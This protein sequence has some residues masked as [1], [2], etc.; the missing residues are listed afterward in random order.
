MP[1]EARITLVGHAVPCVTPTR[2]LQGVCA[3]CAYLSACTQQLAMHLVLLV[4]ACRAK[5]AGQAAKQLRHH[6]K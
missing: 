2:L 6:V 5:L 4:Q 3:K 1:K